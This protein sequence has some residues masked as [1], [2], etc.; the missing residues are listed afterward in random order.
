MD[1]VSY[2][3]GCGRLSCTYFVDGVQDGGGVIG[4][5]FQS[6]ISILFVVNECRYL[7]VIDGSGISRS[8]VLP[9]REDGLWIY[10]DELLITADWGGMPKITWM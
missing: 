7:L 8:E 10:G 6:D 5:E 2:G 9:L 3:G 1:T 4:S